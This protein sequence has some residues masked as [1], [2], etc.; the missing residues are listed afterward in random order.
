VLPLGQEFAC[1]S[2]QQ[3]IG[4][5]KNNAGA[6][7]HNDQPN[8]SAE[9]KKNPN[10]TKQNSTSDQIGDKHWPAVLLCSEMKLTDLALAFFTATLAI[11]GWFT[12]RSTEQIAE[13]VERAY[14][15]HGYTPL[16][17]RGNQAMFTLVMTN[18]GRMPGGV[19]EVGW[20]FLDRDSLPSG[21]E[22]ADWTWETLEYDFIVRPSQKADIRRFLSLSAD[23]IF[24]SYIKYQDMFSKRSHTSWMGM[25]IYPGKGET[26]RAGGDTWNDW[27]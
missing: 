24:V 15:F 19:T 4:A 9:T 16:E 13:S 21:R 6:Q 2:T 14:I 11:I 27:D 23:H 3:N 18:A 22:K 26:A 25:H 20:K 5:P 17:F 10:S 8:T 7:Q 12:L 1:V